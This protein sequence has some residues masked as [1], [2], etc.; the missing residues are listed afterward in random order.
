MP[1][2]WA[3][4]NAGM[5]ELLQRKAVMETKSDEVTPAWL[6][7]QQTMKYCGLGR[8]LLTTLVVSGQIPAAR[9]NRRVLISKAGLDSYL[10]AHTYTESSQE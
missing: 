3:Q 1:L 5:R 7:Y 9:V 2:V 6:S 10:R 4:S 8:T